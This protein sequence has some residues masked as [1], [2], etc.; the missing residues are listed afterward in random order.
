MNPIATKVIKT[1]K[2]K[3][4]PITRNATVPITKAITIPWGL[5]ETIKGLPARGIVI[6]LGKEE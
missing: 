1:T 3:D 2:S 5:P 6:I 4:H